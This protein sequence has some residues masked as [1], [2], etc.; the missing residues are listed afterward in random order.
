MLLGKIQSDLKE[1][2]KIFNSSEPVPGLYTGC[3]R[4]EGRWKEDAGQFF[5]S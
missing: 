1:K 4:K 2:L 3:R 5:F